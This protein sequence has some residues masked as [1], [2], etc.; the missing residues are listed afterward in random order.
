[1]VADLGSQRVTVLVVPADRSKPLQVKNLA[2]NRF[3]A[4]L[5]GRPE[6]VLPIVLSAPPVDWMLFVAAG[7]SS[8]APAN[9]RAQLLC[10][11][12]G[13]APGRTLPGTVLFTGRA[14]GPRVRGVPRIFDQYAALL[15]LHV[16]SI[17]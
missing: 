16:R 6:A 2:P 8:G 15:G 17:E 7:L 13:G 1:M 5:G 4:E 12:L 10:G 9:T 3:E 11:H 14:P